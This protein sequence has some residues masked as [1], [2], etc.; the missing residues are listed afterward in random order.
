MIMTNKDL[1]DFVTTLDK[2]PSFRECL[3][4]TDRRTDEQ[5]RMEL[6]IRLLVA[7][8]INWD[9]VGNYNDYAE[10]LDKETINLCEIDLDYEEVGSRFKATFDLL[11][12][13]L[14][15]NTFKKYNGEKHVG[16]VLAAAFQAIAYGIYVNINEILKL[17]NRNDL[18]IEKVRKIYQEEVY[19]RNTAPGV[20]SIPRYKELSLFGA[21]YFSV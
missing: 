17:D 9:N 20:R 14:G 7:E 2:H 3:P 8:K 11:Y 10:L 12:G 13:I 15:E 6:L 21:E 1:Y 16:P 19:M 4:I 18:I 5:Y